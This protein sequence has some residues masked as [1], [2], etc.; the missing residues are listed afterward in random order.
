MLD[1][2]RGGRRVGRPGDDPAH[3]G[4]GQAA[5]RRADQARPQLAR[6][7]LPGL[8]RR[9]DRRHDNH[10]HR[11]HRPQPTIGSEGSCEPA[12]SLCLPRVGDLDCS[13]FLADKKPVRITG[14]TEPARGCGRRCARPSGGA[15][16]Q[17]RAR[18]GERTR[19]SSACTCREVIDPH[20]EQTRRFL[21]VTI[22]GLTGRRRASWSRWREPGLHPERLVMPDAHQKCPGWGHFWHSIRPPRAIPARLPR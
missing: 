10:H 11:R 21:G 20:G 2:L 14:F 15:R 22:T 17:T 16:E 1:H 12:Y 19:R 3:P 13:D 5:R 7:C 8:R 6:L 4:R 9:P 18:G